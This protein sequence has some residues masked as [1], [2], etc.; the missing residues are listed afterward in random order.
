[1]AESRTAERTSTS[2]PDVSMR[3]IHA[4]RWARRAFFLL[5]VAIVAAA[6]F[7]RLGNRTESIAASGGGYELEVRYPRVTRPGLAVDITIEIRRPGGFGGAV[8][9]AMPSDYLAVFDE[10]GLDPDPI[11]ATTTADDVRWQFQAPL[12]SDTM[13]VSFDIRVQPDVELRR[14]GGSVAVLDDDGREAVS[15][16]F[17]T[18]VLP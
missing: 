12:D 11:G 15:V 9:L 16:E 6:L 17:E 4:A 3:R 8:M 10:N 2:P 18:I 5:V 13:A 1:V 14:L 7:G